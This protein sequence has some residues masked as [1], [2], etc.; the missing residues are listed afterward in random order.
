MEGKQAAK[1][2]GKAGQR[3]R[4]DL[5]MFRLTHLSGLDAAGKL[6]NSASLHDVPNSLSALKQ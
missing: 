4:R 2:V 1:Q 5:Q 6:L 3:V